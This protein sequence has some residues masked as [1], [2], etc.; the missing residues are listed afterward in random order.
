MPLVRA[1]ARI[2]SR[3]TFAVHFRPFTA[4]TFIPG[5]RPALAAGLLGRRS[6]ISPS[7]VR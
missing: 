2:A 5:A 4:V 6:R 1:A 7:S 3:M